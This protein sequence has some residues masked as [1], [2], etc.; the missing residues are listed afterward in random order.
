MNKKSILTPQIMR[1]IAT[2]KIW[3]WQSHQIDHMFCIQG[4][5]GAELEVSI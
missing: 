3:N 2:D 1:K 4:E 5:V